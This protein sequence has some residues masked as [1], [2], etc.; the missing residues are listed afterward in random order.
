MLLIDA[1]LAR[2][3]GGS[4]F[5]HSPI[6]QQEVPRAS[7]EAFF[8]FGTTLLWIS[9]KFKSDIFLSPLR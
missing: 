1:Q 3:L 6:F 4:D 2:S 8:C 5:V 7:E 9:S